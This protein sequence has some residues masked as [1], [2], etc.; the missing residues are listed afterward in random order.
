MA[1]KSQ[2]NLVY[3]IGSALAADPRTKNAVIEVIDD[4]GVITLQGKVESV[5]ARNAAEGIAAQQGGVATVI[6]EL[7]VAFS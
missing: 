7:V 1:V 4:R 2:E 3:Q 6:N 5:K